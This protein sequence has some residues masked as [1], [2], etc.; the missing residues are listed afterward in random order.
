MV[1]EVTNF[2]HERIGIRLPISPPITILTN[3]SPPLDLVLPE[4][5]NERTDA[6]VLY[7][8]ASGIRPTWAARVVS[9]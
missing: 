6:G 4:E 2:E 7:S 8:I 9:A 1:N 3:L 5:A